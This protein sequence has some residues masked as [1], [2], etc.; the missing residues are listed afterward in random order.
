MAKQHESNA[1]IIFLCVML[2]IALPLS[3]WFYLRV[4]T[5]EAGDQIR[6]EQFKALRDEMKAEL[7]RLQ[8]AR[9]AAEKGEDK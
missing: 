4:K 5:V 9:K 7:M 2:G 6:Q 1:L 3:A 8:A